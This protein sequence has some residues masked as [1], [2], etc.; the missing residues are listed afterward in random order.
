MIRSVKALDAGLKWHLSREI[1]QSSDR[2][3]AACKLNNNTIVIAVYN[4]SVPSK[5]LYKTD[6]AFKTLRPISNLSL[7]LPDLS[8]VDGLVYTR[9]NLLVAGESQIVPNT[10][11]Y[12][13]SWPIIYKSNDNG[14]TWHETTLRQ[15]IRSAS[16]RD[17]S[18]INECR[19]WVSK[20]VKDSNE[21]L[22][23]LTLNEGVWK[24]TDNGDTWNLDSSLDDTN[25]MWSDDLY[26]L[27]NGRILSR[28]ADNQPVYTD[29]NG[30]HWTPCQIPYNLGSTIFKAMTITSEDIVVIVLQSGEF[31]YSM[32]NGATFQKAELD[33][34]HNILSPSSSMPDYII[35]LDDKLV[36]VFGRHILISM[37]EYSYTINEYL[38]DEVAEELVKQFKAYVDSLTG[39]A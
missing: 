33:I 31:I 30:D 34:D 3:W 18:N 22:Y 17:M 12:G 24:S 16:T 10:Y 14:A 26:K 35:P 5:T 15:N 37:P 23:V 4:S 19:S 21:D 38:D 11:G 28:N 25:D 9:N 2:L 7:D 39:G 20:I 32:D 6:D 36:T 1:L 13:T 27:S 8:N 29:D